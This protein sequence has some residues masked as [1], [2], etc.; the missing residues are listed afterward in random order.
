MPMHVIFLE[1]A[2]PANQRQFV[3]ALHEA[4]A[5]V[6]GIG[7]RPL[8]YL[9]DQLKSWLYSYEQVATSAR[10]DAVTEAV[11]KIQRRGPWVHKLD[12]TEEALMLCA[13]ESRERTGIPGMSVAHTELCRDK[14]KMK[15][16]LRSK[17]VP[18]AKAAEV[19]TMAE[20][21]AF[22][23]QVGFPVILKP[24]A[25]AGAAGTYKIESLDQMVQ[26]AKESNLGPNRPALLE[27]FV[28]GHEG[29]YDTLTVGGQVV[30]ETVS[31][32]YPN[33]LEAMRTRDLSP[34]VMT[35]NRIDAQGY[36]VLKAFGR[37]VVQALD[38]DTTATHME[39]FFGSKGLYF[40]EI[41]ARPP[42]VRVWDLYCAAN[43]LD[44]YREWANAVVHGHA[45]PR[46][47][48]RYSAGMVAIRPN[49]DGRVA[50]Y[51][52][53]AEVQRRYGEAILEM[54]LPPP[55]TRTNGVGSGYMGNAWVWARHPDYDVCRRILED[56]GATLKMWAE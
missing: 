48:R 14:Y 18:C 17:G 47:S 50:G 40:S 43:D 49:K 10:T 38:L 28:S 21:K 23:E 1:P 52:G 7:D 25:G 39:W 56:I 29:F 35:T 31:H 30:F 11:Q 55:G 41:G 4:G 36:G 16:F 33:V 6:S 44:L 54:Y 12:C 42:G 15:Q 8:Q 32:Y 37:Q 51:S 46:P 34:I 20:A 24:L 9:D 3:R 27:E 5:L 2:F 45:A 26:A 53:V 22:I 19:G 13:A